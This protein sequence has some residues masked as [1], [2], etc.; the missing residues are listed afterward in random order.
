M[1]AALLFLVGACASAPAKQ[2]EAPAP[3][4]VE[5]KVPALAFEPATVQPG[6]DGDAWAG[7]RFDGGRPTIKRVIK[8]GPAAKAGLQAGDVVTQL[9]NI[10]AT[11]ASELV[12]YIRAHHVGDTLV[13]VVDR[14][15]TTKTI[16]VQIA[17]KPPIEDLFAAEL[18]GNP[19]PDFAAQHASGPH[20]TSL[21]DLKGQ[22]VLVEFWA[23][24]C[25]P[26]TVAQPYLDKW[27]TTYGPK[28]LRVVAITN[29]SVP[30]VTD[31]LTT[32]WFSYSIGID[33]DGEISANYMVPGTPTL[34]VIDRSGIV[35][36]VHV[37]ADEVWTLESM[38]QQLL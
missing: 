8:L 14:G 23:T 28:G 15:G 21:A 6:V 37:G 26:C 33:A 7:I 35:R 16:D 3:A 29:E 24:W 34:V 22:V 9:D 30:T 4:P 13:F 17:L 31:Y 1:R 20:A 10:H 38:I 19:A 32:H 2:P 25:G 27:Q 12:T 11:G 18:T 36:R 5:K